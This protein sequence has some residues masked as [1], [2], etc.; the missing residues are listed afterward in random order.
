MIKTER[1]KMKKALFICSSPRKNSNTNKI[2]DMVIDIF[3]EKNIEAIK[4]DVA[5]LKYKTNGCIDCGVCQKSEKY[6]C[7]IK[8]EATPI[9]EQ[10]PQVDYLIFATPVYFMGPNAQLKLLLDRMQS[11]Y[12]FKDSGHTSCIDHLKIGLIST[13]GGDL[14]LGLN[15]LDETMKVLSDYTGAEYCSILI[16]CAGGYKDIAVEGEVLNKVKQ[17]ADNF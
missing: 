3:K 10:I 16:P 2:V 13:G 9:L 1:E 5:N 6:G 4:V 7:V 14:D 17:F 15:L 12:K 8:D 11:L